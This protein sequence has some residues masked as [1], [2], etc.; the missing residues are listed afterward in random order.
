MVSASSPAPAVTAPSTGGGPRAEVVCDSISPA[1]SRLTTIE[2][3]LHRFVLAE[4]NTHRAFSRNSASSRAI[5]VKR[6]LEAVLQD[7]A[8]PLE[9]GANQRGMQAGPPLQGEDHE[10]ALAAW[11]D[12]RDGA[13][14]AAERLLELGV[15]KQVANRILE[16][17]IWHT[18][19]VTA[20]DW[21]GFWQQRCSPLA[22]PEI[23]A[24]ADAMRAAFDAST[25]VEVAEDDWHTP[26]IRDDERDL[27]VE[28]RKRIA[29]ARCARVSYL[30]HDGRRDLSADEELYDRLVTAEPPHWSPLEH[31]ATPAAGAQPAGNLRGW[32]QLRHLIEVDRTATR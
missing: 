6:Q 14:A 16:P 30:T 21:D 22:Q 32:R 5:P 29:A 12:A 24:A 13:V 18:V 11:L 3:T 31:V 1:G 7:P 2:V 8:V 9:F 28:T 26:Y 4:L 25:P 23:R 20:T 19:I 27:D 10:R 17:F 15:H